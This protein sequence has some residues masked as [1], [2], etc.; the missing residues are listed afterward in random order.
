MP[1]KFL[2]RS[3]FHLSA[4][5][6]I[7][8]L[9]SCGK[10]AG[11]SRAAFRMGQQMQVGPLIYNVLETKWVSQLGDMLRQRVPKQRFLLVRISVTNSGGQE[12]SLPFLSLEDAKGQ[13]YPEEQSGEGVDGWMGFLRTIQ[14]A[15]TENGWLVFDV[16]PGSYNLRVSGET[17]S[18][19][20]QSVL[21]HIPLSVDSMNDVLPKAEP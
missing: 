4:L 15:Q 16:A 20:E 13:S 3:A 21:I 10:N 1:R 5:A 19:D 9:I 8:L 2:L 17:S 7:I 11:Q 14:P 18:G 6:A 12:V